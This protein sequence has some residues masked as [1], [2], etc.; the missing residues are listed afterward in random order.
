MSNQVNDDRSGDLVARWREGDQGAAEVLFRR[1]ANRL[2]ALA[3]S[4]LS[5]AVGRRVDPEDVVQ[6]VY[7]SFFA[8]TRAGRYEFQRGGDLWQ[9]LVTIT[10]HKL[11]DQIKYNRRAKRAVQ[12]EQPFGSE[13]SLQGL[14]AHMLGHAPSALEAVALVDQVEQLM[15]QLEPLHRR[16]LELR[17]QGYDLEEIAAATERTQRTVSRVLDR[18]KRLIQEQYQVGEQAD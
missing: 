1:Y 16:M 8:D 4:Q 13:D 9:L 12:R 11:Q 15:R 5:A 14:Q 6:S 2:V 18:I 7:R 10:L 3:R 17:L